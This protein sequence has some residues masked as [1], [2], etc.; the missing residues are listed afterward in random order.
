MT[1]YTAY[2]ITTTDTEFQVKVA[3]HHTRHP[4]NWF[5]TDEGYAVENVRQLAA[6]QVLPVVFI[7]EDGTRHEHGVQF[8]PEAFERAAYSGYVAYGCSMTDGYYAPEAFEAWVTFFRKDPATAIRVGNDF[9][10]SEAALAAY[11]R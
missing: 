3:G 5:T 6:Q 1:T 10:P 9:Y 2:R 4:M 11:L 8:T 7:D